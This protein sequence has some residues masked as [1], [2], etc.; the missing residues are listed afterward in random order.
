M[1]SRATDGPVRI[2]L[3]GQ[4]PA[5]AYH[6]ERISLR[7]DMRL[8]AVCDCRAEQ[9]RSD[10]LLRE[11][12]MPLADLLARTDLDY[13]LVAAP[14]NRLCELALRA[15]EAEKNIAVDSPPCLKSGEATALLAASRRTGRAVCVL[16]TR[17]D[18]FDFRAAQHLVL[19]G[20]LGR[21]ESGRIVS[22]A[23][24]VPPDLSDS[25]GGKG[26]GEAVSGEGVFAF[27]AFQYVDQLLQ[28]VGRPPQAVF[29]RI[30]SPPASDPTAAAFFIAVA[31][32]GGGDGLIDVNLHTGGALQ[33]GWM[34]A[35]TTGAYC[36]Q[37]IHMIE[38]SGEICDVPI[39]AS[40][41]PQVDLYADLLQPAHSEEDRT[42]SLR[43]A[44]TVL[45]MLDAARQSSRT[46]QVEEIDGAIGLDS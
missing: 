28:L 39:L 4:G 42:R 33:T 23:K 36:Q 27:F 32:R 43:E 9:D 21:I 3:I 11:L 17:R 37:R 22:W 44:A 29:A 7:P 2:G 18:G 12:S 31:F 20:R 25:S 46:G 6:F 26:L 16:P 19:S 35:G 1:T 41:V 8:V 40:D 38:P 45:R 13:V 15:V 14:R 30:S 10:P 24:A 5:V 34:L